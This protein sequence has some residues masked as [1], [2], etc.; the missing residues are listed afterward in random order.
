MTDISFYLVW[1]NQYTRRLIRNLVCQGAI[2]NVNKESLEVNHQYLSMFTN[3]E[4][5]DHNISIRFMGDDIDYLEIN[6]NNRDLINDVQLNTDAD[7][8]NLNEIHDGVRKLSL[9][10]ENQSVMATGELPPSITFLY[11]GGNGSYDNPPIV[12]PI[13]SNL[14]AN[15]QELDLL[16]HRDSISSPCIMPES[17]TDIK[18]VVYFDYNILKWFVVPPN[19]VYK[20]CMLRVDSME[21]FEWLLENKWICSVD[22]GRNVLEILMFRHQLPSHITKVEVYL[23][24]VRDRSF[25]PP[26][27]E[28]LACYYGT[29]FSHLV[30]LK[31]LK[32][33]G[34]YQTKLEKGVLPAS[35]QELYLEY[36]QPLEVDVLPPNLTTLN[37][38]SYNMPFSSNVLP[39]GLTTLYLHNYNQ[40]LGTNILPSTLTD[41]TLHSFNQ[42]L[43][44]FVLPQKLKRLY[45]GKFT[46]PSI[47][48]NSLPISLTDLT[49]YRFNGSF[50]QC[51]PLDNLKILRV[52]SLFPSL[53]TLLA[54]VEKLYLW[55]DNRDDDNPSGTCLYNTSIKSLSI[56]FLNAKTLYPNSFP[57]TLRYLSLVN[58]Y[59]KPG[60][61]SRDC[62]LLKYR[63]PR[64]YRSF[65]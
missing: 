46:Q 49:V 47:P 26:T 5:Q 63:E 21:S 12:Q 19:K 43:R 30:N 48:P 56:Q 53:A 54:N 7:N 41:L 31:V 24:I 40:P 1:R 10:T 37:L 20:S 39:P 34:E 51:Q 45:M 14:P 9:T 64:P 38:T 6:N 18:S 33:I 8:F 22:I 29:P 25:F 13:L 61:I 60:V 27:L 15:L 23:E 42:P 2:I 44:A 32:I 4:K 28:S 62:V 3:K 57:P 16:I 11:L 59:L 55:I 58:A 35:L 17:L 36:N 65:K 50:D 52:D